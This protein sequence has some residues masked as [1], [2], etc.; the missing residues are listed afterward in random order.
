MQGKTESEFSLV[1]V[2][3]REGYYRDAE[4]GWH[5]DRRLN[6][7]RRADRIVELH[8]RGIRKTIR[9]DSDREMWDYL[10]SNTANGTADIRHVRT[11]S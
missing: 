6:P 3:V 10:M 8:I 9:R 7:D 4:G 5:L 2:E 11:A 1:N